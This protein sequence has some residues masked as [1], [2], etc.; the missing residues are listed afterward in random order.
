MDVGMHRI[1]FNLPRHEGA[2]IKYLGKPRRVGN[3][4]AD[5]APHA[6]RRTG[7]GPETRIHV[8]TGS[9][10]GQEIIGNCYGRTVHERQ[11]LDEISILGALMT[12]HTGFL[13]AFLEKV[14]GEWHLVCLALNIK[15]MGELAAC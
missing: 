6:R 8:R 13:T 10:D 11:A 12:N 2:E 3:D 15:R 9:I 14:R 5:D 7:D 1:H 4:L